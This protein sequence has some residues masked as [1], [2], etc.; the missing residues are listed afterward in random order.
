MPVR[1]NGEVVFLS[2]SGENC[3]DVVVLRAGYIDFVCD[4]V[5][6]CL[7]SFPRGISAEAESVDLP[8]LECRSLS[9]GVDR[10]GG[11]GSLVNRL[12]VSQNVWV[13][14]CEGRQVCAV[15]V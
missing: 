9:S 13:V 10:S 2:P 7:D 12:V 3:L 4:D 6:G 1:D 14:R 15:S 5:G 11:F 8:V